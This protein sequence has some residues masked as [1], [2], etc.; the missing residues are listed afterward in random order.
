MGEKLEYKVPFTGLALGNHEFVFEIGNAFFESY[1]YSEIN[2]A[3]CQIRMNMEKQSTMLVLTFFISGSVS[4]PCDRCSDHME[5]EI[6]GEYGFIAKYSDEGLPDTDEIVYLPSSEYQVDVKDS[7]YEFI[8][9]SLPSR[10]AHEDGECNEEMMQA[11]N[12][13]LVTESPTS[14]DDEGFDD[15]DES[16]EE[17]ENDSEESNVDP[18]WAAL[19]KLKKEN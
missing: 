4:L 3:N 15:F 10:H 11:L 5:V 19:N 6:D 12:Q 7:I 13:Y 16:E 8:Q 9:L 17:E 2:E 1:E 14:E 18:R